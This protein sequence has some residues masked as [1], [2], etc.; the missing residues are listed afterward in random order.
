VR[1]L[2]EWGN[3]VEGRHILIA[4]ARYLAAHSPTE[5]AELQ[6]ADIAQRLMRDGELHQDTPRLTLDNVAYVVLALL[7][8]LGVSNSTPFEIVGCI[9]LQLG[10]GW[11]C[12]SA[13]REIRRL[14]PRQPG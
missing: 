8:V 13:S 4:V 7:L 2:G 3:T 5:R 1:Q 11:H 10:V 12:A 9:V 14:F 6:T